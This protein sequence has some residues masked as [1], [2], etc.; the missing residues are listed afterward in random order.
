M[1]SYLGKTFLSI[2]LTMS[3][4]MPDFPRRFDALED[5]FLDSDWND[6]SW[7]GVIIMSAHLNGACGLQSEKTFETTAGTRF[8]ALTKDPR[9]S[10][11]QCKRRISD[12][13]FMFKLLLSS[14]EGEFW[15]SF[16]QATVNTS[17]SKWYLSRGA[18]RHGKLRW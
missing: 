2:Y 7:R 3:E 15:K 18:L 14:I 11:A 9:Q 1:D 17:L 13:I 6:G 8:I 10:S 16:Q 5:A 4:K 12:V